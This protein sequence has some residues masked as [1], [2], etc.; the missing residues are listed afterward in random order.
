M[1]SYIFGVGFEMGKE[2][3]V[4]AAALGA[5]H[6]MRIYTPNPIILQSAMRDARL[7]EVLTRADICLADGVGIG[8]AA[9]IL[10][11]PR[12]PRRA[13]IE[14]AERLTEKAEEAG[15]RVFLFGGRP[16]VA[17][18][19]A[20]ALRKKHPR[21]Q[22]CGA[23]HGYFDEGFSDTLAAYIRSKRPDI[24]FVCLG[25]PQQEKFIDQYLHAIGA[26]IGMGLGGSLDV[27]A[28]DVRRAPRPIRRMGLEW[29]WRM[30]LEPRRLRG[31]PHMAAFLLSA[32]V[33]RLKNTVKMHRNGR[34]I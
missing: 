6:P 3:D 16:Q 22:I 20:K 9:R 33:Q 18:R 14:F 24:L 30:L 10:G 1:K 15:L 11:V 34:G 17:E 4:L 31:L 8:I 2:E 21:L 7:M 28:N 19:A 32:L 5:P 13:G 23:C 25:S 27:W 26:R 29:L 12:P